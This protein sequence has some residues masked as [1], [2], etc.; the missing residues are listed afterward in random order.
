M[1]KNDF[2]FYALDWYKKRTA[3]EFSNKFKLPKKTI[4]NWKH[5]I[6]I[7]ERMAREKTKD[8]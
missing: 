5:R 8:W 7:A 1:G 6:K 4:Y 3:K 2:L